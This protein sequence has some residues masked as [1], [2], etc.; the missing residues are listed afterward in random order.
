MAGQNIEQLMQVIDYGDFLQRDSLYIFENK[1]MVKSIPLDIGIQVSSGD[2]VQIEM[3]D[4]IKLVHITGK[5]IR[6]LQEEEEIF[7]PH[8]ESVLELRD[9]YCP[10]A[11]GYGI[12]ETGIVD[13]EGY[14]RTLGGSIYFYDIKKE[15][16]FPDEDI[17]KMRFPKKI[18]TKEPIRD[19]K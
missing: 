14:G 4:P 5:I 19:L 13:R 11:N 1:K 9:K 17:L 7:L 12:G 3:P 18:K 15:Y 2:Y 6:I 10:Q 8:P 16:Y